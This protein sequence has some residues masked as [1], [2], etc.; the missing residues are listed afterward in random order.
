MVQIILLFQAGGRA[1]ITFERVAINCM[2]A[3]IPDNAGQTPQDEAI[4]DGSLALHSTADVR[5]LA[6]AIQDAGIPAQVSYS[7]GAYVCNDLYYQV[8]DYFQKADR[9]LPVCFIHVPSLSDG[10]TYAEL[11]KALSAAILSLP[12]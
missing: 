8:L 11:S 3:R 4:A 2:S 6:Q 7:A 1:A 12:A 9:P 5:K 10:F